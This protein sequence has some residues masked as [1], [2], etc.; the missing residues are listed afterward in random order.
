[1]EVEVVEA[2]EVRPRRRRSAPVEE[3]YEDEPRPTRS[4]G[5][6]YARQAVQAPAIG[7]MVSGGIG[8]VLGLI[9]C[10]V[11]VYTVV[12]IG[13]QPGVRLNVPYV[14]GQVAGDILLIALSSVVI[15]GALKMQ[16][17][18]SIGS[19]RTACIL[20][21]LPCGGFCLLGLPFG[22]WGLVTLSNPDVQRA[23]G[24]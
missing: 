15:A 7:L 16:R 9:Y 3:D 12:A 13:R 21:M 8:V 17:L 6:A 14:I 2:V 10:C 24:R 20:G 4:R 22:I 19:A 18:E 23:F 5:R 1:L 11:T